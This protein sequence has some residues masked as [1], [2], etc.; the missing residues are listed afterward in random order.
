MVLSFCYQIS[1]VQLF[2]TLGFS[3]TSLR[4]RQ[5]EAA[6][7]RERLEGTVSGGELPKLDKSEFCVVDVKMCILSDN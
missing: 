5:E 7:E 6:S 1:D 4:H 2:T 3:P